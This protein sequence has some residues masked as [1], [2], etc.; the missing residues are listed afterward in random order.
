MGMIVYC[1]CCLGTQ[2]TWFVCKC[3]KGC[4]MCKEEKE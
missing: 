2:T 4:D 3:C 1:E